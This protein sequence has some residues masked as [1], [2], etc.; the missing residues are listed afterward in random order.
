MILSAGVWLINTIHI[1]CNVVIAVMLRFCYVQETLWLRLARVTR[2]YV[3]YV[4]FSLYLYF[5]YKV[6]TV[7]LARSSYGHFSLFYTTVTSIVW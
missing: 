3:L 5:R 4:P 6:S 1:H 2:N 7:E